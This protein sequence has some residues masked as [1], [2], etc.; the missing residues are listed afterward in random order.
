MEERKIDI[1][2]VPLLEA[3]KN[4]IRK[5]LEDGVRSIAAIAK[6]CDVSKQ[7]VYRM[8]RDDP[9]LREAH[10]AA[11]MSRMEE[12]EQVAMDL[13]ENGENEMAR[14]KV[15]ET[16]LKGRMSKIYSDALHKV[17]DPNHIPRRINVMPILPIVK[18]NAD[19]IPL[20]GQ[21]LPESFLKKKPI[22]IDVEPK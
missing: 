17:N 13:A 2:P 3:Q 1:A 9:D 7:T 21:E 8:L 15:L 14:A 12:I 16:L 20:E 19:G 10:E 11:W 4:A 5:L 6:A 18:T 22:I